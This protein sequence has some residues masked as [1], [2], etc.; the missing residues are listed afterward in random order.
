MTFSHVA[1]LESDI[2]QAYFAGYFL[3]HTD[4]LAD[5]VD[6]VEVAFWKKYGEGNAWK[7]TARAKVHQPRAVGERNK[8]GYCQRMKD[9]VN[10]K[11][12]NI[13]A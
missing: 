6:E 12:V 9:M 5:A 13:L 4:F 7:A 3:R 8:F 1:M 2:C 11:I 10:H